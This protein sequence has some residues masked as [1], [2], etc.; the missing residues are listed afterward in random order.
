V[1]SSALQFRRFDIPLATRGHQ[2]VAQQTG[3]GHRTDATWY[4]RYR[5]CDFPGLVEIDIAD[6]TGFTI[7]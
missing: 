1:D 7:G 5:S 6:E 2:R 4:R 3:D